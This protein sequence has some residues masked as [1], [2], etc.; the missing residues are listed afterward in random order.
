MSMM[1]SMT[2]SMCIVIIFY[3]LSSV[4]YFT[5]ETRFFNWFIVA[6]AVVAA[7]TRLFLRANRIYHELVTLALQ[8]P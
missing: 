1:I 7:L 4:S 3:S 6:S 8:Y 2:M 5:G